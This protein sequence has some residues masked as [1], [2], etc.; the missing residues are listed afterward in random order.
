[1]PRLFI[2]HAGLDRELV[3]EFVNTIIRLGC[4][5]ERS[6]IFYS[7]SPGMG[8]PSGVA[9]NA[10]IRDKVSEADL[11][12]AIITPAFRRSAY[13]LAELGAAWSRSGNLF[14]IKSKGIQLEDLDGILNGLVVRDLDDSA[15]LDELH[16][17][18]NELFGKSTTTTNWTDAKTGWLHSVG[19]LL[20][21]LQILERRRQAADSASVP[22]AAFEDPARHCSVEHNVP[23]S[24]RMGSVPAG[25]ELWAVVA[26]NWPAA[27]YHPQGNSLTLTEAGFSGSVY[28]GNSD[29]TGSFRL[30]LVLLDD[31]DSEEFRRY[32]ESPN[33]K[34]DYPGLSQL[35][36]SAKILDEIV[37]ARRSS[38]HI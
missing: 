9:L 4:D 36:P 6:D 21:K 27:R 32:Q 38:R 14:P 28:V 11:V 24:G 10:Y 35:P 23:V 5:V 8:V 26:G 20:S 30:L 17:R 16:D 18:A 13:C 31:A 25:T 37:V 7:S 12:V 15:A 3:T 29:S 22:R 33:R 19:G 34:K 1:M 2:S